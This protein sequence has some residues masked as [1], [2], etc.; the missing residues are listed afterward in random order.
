VGNRFRRDEEGAALAEYALLVGLI[1]VVC[2]IG[3]TALGT[4]VSAAF[5]TI[6]QLTNA[7][8]AK[9]GRGRGRVGQL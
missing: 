4:S 5:S 7:I 3:V 8:R 9:V 6:A 1:A 2:V